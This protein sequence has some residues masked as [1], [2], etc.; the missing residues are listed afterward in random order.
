MP[1]QVSRG[2]C[3]F[4]QKEL[5]KP[6][7]LRHLAVCEQRVAAQAEEGQQKRQKSTVF[8]IQVEGFRLPMYW[9]HLEVAADMPLAM[10]DRFLRNTWVECCGHL[11]VFRIGELNYYVDEDVDNHY[12]WDKKGRDMQ[13]R[14]D[15]VLSPGQAFSYEYDFGSTTELSLT[16]ISAREIA[17]K[18]KPVQVLAR[19]NL[20]LIPCDVCGKP[21]TYVCAEC[22]YN[23]EG[24]LCDECARIHKCGKEMLMPRAN[25]PREG[26]CGYTGQTSAYIFR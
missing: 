14:L 19:N 5:S 12:Y 9:M 22:I 1:R 4:C 24:C 17:G 10:L 18:A 23:D 2:K 8:H 7:M 26:V 20:P 25:S 13:A 3:N 11:S 6:A 15:K 16:V 21:S